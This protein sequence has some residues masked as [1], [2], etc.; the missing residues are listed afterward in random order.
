M[1]CLMTITHIVHL[2][3]RVTLVYPC[4]VVMNFVA[5][6]AYD[7]LRPSGLGSLALHMLP[8]MSCNYCD[9]CRP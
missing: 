3:T 4:G 5:L 8:L 6:F 9:V 7:P 1:G 2:R